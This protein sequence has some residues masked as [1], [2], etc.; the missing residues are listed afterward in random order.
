MNKRQWL[1]SKHKKV[2]ADK[3]PEKEY[4]QRLDAAILSIQQKCEQD[5]DIILEHIISQSVVPEVLKDDSDNYVARKAVEK[6]VYVRL[7]RRLAL[8]NEE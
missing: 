5:W 6:R 7:Y 8:I 1:N 2:Q 3:S 4:K